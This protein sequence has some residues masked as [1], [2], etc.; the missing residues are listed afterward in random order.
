MTQVYAPFIG[1][2]P[3]RIAALILSLLPTAE[4]SYGRYSL[5]VEGDDLHL[6]SGVSAR[7]GTGWAF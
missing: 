4:P 2:D 5:V 1:A 6:A 7:T 3:N